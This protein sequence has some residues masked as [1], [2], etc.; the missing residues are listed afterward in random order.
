MLQL[1]EGSDRRCSFLRG[2]P[3]ILKNKSLMVVPIA[4]GGHPK[5]ANEGH[6]KTGQRGDPRP[7]EPRSVQAGPARRLRTALRQRL[8][9][10]SGDHR[11]RIGAWPQRHVDLARSGFR[12]RLFG[13]LSVHEALR[14]QA[15]WIPTSRSGGNHPDQGWRKKAKSTTVTDRWC[16]IRRRASTDA[17]GCS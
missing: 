13:Q 12:S 10:V 2:S 16:A 8:R 15:T 7:W 11:T 4:L 3:G 9:T 17:R 1:L 5:A 14:A 6:L